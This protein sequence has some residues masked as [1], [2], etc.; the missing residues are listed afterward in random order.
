MSPKKNHPTIGNKAPKSLSSNAS[1][2]VSNGNPP[3]PKKV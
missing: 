3:P 1:Q 2:P